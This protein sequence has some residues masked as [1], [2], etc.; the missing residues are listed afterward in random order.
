MLSL[1]LGNG[2][3]TAGELLGYFE[4]QWQS[5]GPAYNRLIASRYSTF[6]PHVVRLT[7]PPTAAK[8][9]TFATHGLP[10]LGEKQGSDSGGASENNGHERATLNAPKTLSV[11]RDTTLREI[12]PLPLWGLHATR[13]MASYGSESNV[14]QKVSA[15]LLEVIAAS[16]L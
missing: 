13:S 10:A 7:L 3:R 4:P 6:Y 14:Q 1:R 8:E 5:P 11:P 12:W 9:P 16:G 2:Q 15:A